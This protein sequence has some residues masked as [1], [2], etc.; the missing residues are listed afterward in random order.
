MAQPKKDVWRSKVN[1]VEI[2]NILKEK[3]GKKSYNL[4]VYCFIFCLLITGK[5]FVDYI[6]VKQHGF[7]PVSM[8][9]VVQ[10]QRCSISQAMQPNWNIFI[11][12]L[13]Q[14]H[15]SAAIGSFDGFAIATIKNPLT[16]P[17][18]LRTSLI[19][20]LAQ[21]AVAATFH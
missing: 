20:D 18:T 3:V 7:R 21:M 11:K 17:T 4:E 16:H 6:C 14:A 9:L 1:F 10:A 5:L 2:F 8:L 12:R 19:L 15:N 13:S